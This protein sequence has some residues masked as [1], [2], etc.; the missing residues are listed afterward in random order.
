MSLGRHAASARAARSRRRCPGPG[1]ARWRSARS[2]R[3][4]PGGASAAF[5]MRPSIGSTTACAACRIGAGARSERSQADGVRARERGGQVAQVPGRRA[6]PAA[7]GAVVV[8]GGGQPAVLAAQQRRR[9]AGRASSR[10]WAS[11]TSTWR[12]RAETRARTCGL[13]AQEGDG[14]QQRGRRSR[15]RPAR[16][17]CGR[18]SRRGRRTRARARRAGRPAGSAAA[19]RATSSAV[20]IA[21]LRRSMRAMTDGQQRGRVA[22]EVVDAGA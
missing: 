22:L 3:S 12:Q 7:H 11:S 15:A 21:S 20:T 5:S 16:A 19:Q 8:A 1:R 17:A 6:A 10:S 9:G 2:A 14:A 4:P 13:V 18:G